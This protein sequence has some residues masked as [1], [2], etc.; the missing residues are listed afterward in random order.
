MKAT[1]TFTLPEEQEAFEL[2]V[3]ASKLRGILTGLD[4]HLRGRVKYA[5]LTEEQAESYEGIRDHL[6][7]LLQDQDV[8]LYP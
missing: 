5:D 7:A 1:L 3:S 4:E 6:H 2:A 8:K